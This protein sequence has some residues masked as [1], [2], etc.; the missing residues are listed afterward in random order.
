MIA[1]AI[2]KIFAIVMGVF[3]FGLALLSLAKRKMTEQF[4]LTWGIL[5]VLMIVCGFLLQPS[6]LQRYISVNSLILILLI[7]VGI[8]WGLWVISNHVSELTRKNQEL[9][10]QISLLNQDSEQILEELKVLR[11]AL[12]EQSSTNGGEEN[13]KEG[14]ICH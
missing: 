10:M 8:I 13:E 12:Q 3:L 9:A 14:T 1:G 5:S 2:L 6:Q 11:K 4:C 7:A